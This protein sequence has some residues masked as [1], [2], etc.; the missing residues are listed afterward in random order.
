MQETIKVRKLETMGRPLDKA[1]NSYLVNIAGYTLLIDGGSG[2][3]LELREEKVDYVLLTHWHWDH[4]LSI[5]RMPLQ[6][7]VCASERTIKYISESAPS[8]EGY[9]ALVKAFSKVPPEL[10]SIAKASFSNTSEI[11]RFFSAR[12]D[13][14]IKLSDCEPVRLSLVKVI[15]C[16]GHS[17]DHVCY[18]VDDHAFVGDS[19]NPGEGLTLLSVPDYIS[20]IMTLMA[21]NSWR[22]AHPGHGPDIDRN[23]ASSW[24]SELI[25]GKIGKLL[26]LRSSLSP[27]WRPLEEYL[28]MLYPE[29]GPVAKWIGARSLLGYAFS[30]EQL[31]MVELKTDSSPWM[32]RAKGS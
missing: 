9:G 28:D 4:V 18:I 14:L 11:L 5:V 25:R 8:Y 7:R 17:D 13:W 24:A 26:K 22:V 29:A 6:A 12:K 19:V 15:S 21:D 31:G 20:S 23:E 32:I 1:A 2:P 30:L 27:E 16:P 3:P 10:L